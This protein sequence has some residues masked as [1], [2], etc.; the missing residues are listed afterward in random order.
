MRRIALLASSI[1]AVAAL[2]PAPAALATHNPCDPAGP[3]CVR[4]NCP[5]PAGGVGWFWID[6]HGIPHVDL[7]HCPPL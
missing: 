1:G 5:A 2:L 6:H 3:V 7:R 4:F